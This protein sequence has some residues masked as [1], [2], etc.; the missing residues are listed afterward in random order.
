[1]KQTAKHGSFDFQ[2]SKA[3][4]PYFAHDFPYAISERYFSTNFSLATYF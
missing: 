3:V 4:T 1:M 2:A